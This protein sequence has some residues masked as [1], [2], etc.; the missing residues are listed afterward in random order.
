MNI[1]YFDNNNSDQPVLSTPAAISL[2]ILALTSGS[3]IIC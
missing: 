1:N 3:L 2:L